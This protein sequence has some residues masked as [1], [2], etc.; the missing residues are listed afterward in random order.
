MVRTLTPLALGVALG[1]IGFWL[2]GS[3]PRAAFA[4]N[5]R[6]EQFILCTGMSGVNPR[7]PLDGV[8]LLDH[9]QGKLLAT[10][11]DRTIGKV[12]GFAELDLGKE[13]GVGSQ[14]GVNFLMTTGT[15]TPGQSAL[16]LVEANSGKFGVYTLGPALDGGSGVTILRHDLT[17]F[18]KAGN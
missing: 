15:I 1:A 18:R 13:F 12:T 3:G 9:K 14:Q 2:V 5:D 10:L 6:A 8:W 17:S 11:V 7:S 16:Y 4:A